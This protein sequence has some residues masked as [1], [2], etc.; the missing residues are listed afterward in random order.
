MIWDHPCKAVYTQIQKSLIS[1]QSA[2]SW[3]PVCINKILNKKSNCRRFQMHNA[4]VTWLLQ[5]RRIRCWSEDWHNA[6][7]LIN[8]VT[9]GCHYDPGTTSE[10]TVVIRTALPFACQ[11]QHINYWTATM[12]HEIYS[13]SLNNCVCSTIFETINN[14]TAHACTYVSDVTIRVMSLSG[15]QSEGR[16]Q[17]SYLTG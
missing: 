9:K 8:G 3:H 1:R 15:S 2:R 10:V 5:N 14:G 17:D 13:T 12:S 6:S 16:V 7:F 11:L 4:H